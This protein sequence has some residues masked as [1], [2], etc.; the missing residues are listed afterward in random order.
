MV[1][2]IIK[3]DGVKIPIGSHEGKTI[4]FGCDHRGFKYKTEILEFLKQK[5]YSIID[6][7]A[8]SNER[9]D[10]PKIS[11]NIGKE[12]SIDPYNRVGIG[13]CGSGIGILIPASKYP[14]V[15]IARCLNPKEAET[16]RKHNNTNV[17]G[18]GADLIDLETVLTIIDAWLRT[19]FYSDSQTEK[20]YLNRYIQTIKLEEDIH[21]SYKQIVS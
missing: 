1:K 13:I 12:V 3:V 9:C 5:S 4:V 11:D 10:Y 20:P 19:L 7:G 6:V 2:K 17:L 8:F 15:Y 21:N 18:I 16:S 14:K